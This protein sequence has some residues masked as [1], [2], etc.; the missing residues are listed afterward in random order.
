MYLYSIYYMS[1]YALRII[2]FYYICQSTKCIVL[3]Y[4]LRTFRFKN[5]TYGLYIQRRRQFWCER[6]RC[7]RFSPS[8]ILLN[9]L[10]RHEHNFFYSFEKTT[11]VIKIPCQKNLPDQ[12]ITLTSTCKLLNKYIF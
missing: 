8:L 9:S 10:R 5:I 3:N 1:R 2:I 6:L 4:Y 12:N 7:C 11:I